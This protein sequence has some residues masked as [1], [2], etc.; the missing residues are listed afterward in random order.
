MLLRDAVQSVRSMLT[1]SMLGDITILQDAYDPNTDTTLTFRYG[2]ASLS[3]G[4]VLSV[5]LNTFVVLEVASGGTSAV[6]LP[7]A[8]GGP[9]VAAPAGEVV[10]VQPHFTTAAVYRE[11]ISEAAGLSSPL[12]GLFATAMLQSDGVSYTDGVYL[13]DSGDIAAGREILRLIRSEYR[14]GDTYAW[15]EF[16]DCQWQPSGSVVRV[17]QDPPDATE[18]LFT[19]ATTFGTP[20]ALDDD[21]LDFGITDTVAECMT[22]GAAAAMALGWEGRRTQP[23]SQGDSRRAQEVSITGNTSL[24]RM[25]EAKKQARVNEEAARLLSVYGIRQPSTSGGTTWGAR[26]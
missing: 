9:N 4:T 15:Q 16:T 1:G 7:S 2:K 11:L 8:D 25:F 17:F 5:G 14:I 18:Y 23:L 13:I 26:R 6:V 20:T 24:A 22:L 12:N 19:F 21:L 10:Y 3:P